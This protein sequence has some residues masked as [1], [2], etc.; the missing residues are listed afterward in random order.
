M[1]RPEAV[2][3]ER[4][5]TTICY[6]SLTGFVRKLPDEYF[7]SSRCRRFQQTAPFRQAITLFAEY[8]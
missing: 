6:L 7:N 3:H 4:S 2:L 1:I 8:P 5:V